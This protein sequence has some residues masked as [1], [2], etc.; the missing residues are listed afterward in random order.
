MSELDEILKM[1]KKAGP[2]CPRVK[3]NRKIYFDETN[4]IRKGFLK[5][6]GYNVD[7]LENLFFGLGGIAIDGSLDF[8][9]L[10]KYVGA[11]QTPK[12]AKFK[13]FS[14]DNSDFK[15]AI[16][17]KRLRLFFE[18]LLKNNIYIHYCIYHY[19]YFSLVDI[20]DSLFDETDEWQDLYFSDPNGFKS[21]LFE[22]LY[23]NP[24]KLHNLLFKYSFP[25][26]KRKDSVNF[27][28]DV[29]EL[30]REGLLFFDY[31]KIINAKKHVLLHL[32]IAKRNKQ[33]LIFLEDNDDYIISSDMSFTY[34]QR[35]YNF[36][37]EKIFDIEKK[38][39]ESIEKY[40]D[41][42]E[43]KLSVKF[44]DSRE[45]RDIQIS[46]AV[47]GFV[48]R[49][50][51]FLLLNDEIELKKYVDSFDINS[52]EYRTLSIF[53]DLTE[54]SDNYSK[55]L[56]LNILPIYLLNRFEYIQKLIRSKR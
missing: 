40:D 39:I 3:V 30:Y 27:L 17:Q 6:E 21:D 1:Y 20:L 5:E 23:K 43:N 10:L 55:V 45:S 31:H 25:N 49:F 16:K 14:F 29:I 22:V 4:N 26:V 28:S 8:V 36:E 35:M 48:A 19:L 33:S 50:F 2:L 46:D 7:G 9:E 42:Y 53:F 34:L 47:I 13:F 38:I 52:E 56:C 12:D 15:D 51:Q 54:V 44:L 41:D 37:D 11:K 24:N 32:L 18:Y